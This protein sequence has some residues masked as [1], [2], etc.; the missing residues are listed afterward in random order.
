M[1][2]DGKFQQTEDVGTAEF[3]KGRPHLPTWGPCRCLPSMPRSSMFLMTAT[4]T[5]VKLSNRSFSFD[6]A[7][8][9][10]PMRKSC[11]PPYQPSSATKCSESIKKA[12][13][14][15]I[16]KLDHRFISARVYLRLSLIWRSMDEESCFAPDFGKQQ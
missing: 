13:Q 7:R 9:Y 14:N 5:S 15:N 16:L 12:S 6:K 3:A 1:C 11:C 10:P 8:S 4:G 2:V